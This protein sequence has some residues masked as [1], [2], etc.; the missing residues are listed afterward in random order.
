MAD[1]TTALKRVPRWAWFTSAGV[2]IG[3]IV[4]Y[5]IRNRAGVEEP[6]EEGDPTGYPDSYYP[7]P[8][9]A[10]GIVVPDINIPG[11]ASG[12]QGGLALQ[13][14]YLGALSEILAS[15][16]NNNPP[17]VAADP[18]PIVYVLPAGGGG[19]PSESV[20]GVVTVA[21]PPAPAPAPRRT[22][23]ECGTSYN[24]QDKNCR[25]YTI[26]YYN[27]GTNSGKHNDHRMHMGKCGK[28]GTNCKNV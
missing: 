13:E 22:I 26:F 27:D 1:L 24:G 9:G 3:A 12:E 8:S 19:V 25:H 7:S 17:P 4:L 20:G 11:N 21:P 14:M 5:T 2:A 15:I 10:P 18:Q 16:G 28:P 23:R 6:S